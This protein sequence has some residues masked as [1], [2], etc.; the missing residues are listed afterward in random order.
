MRTLR[1]HL[2]EAHD[3]TLQQRPNQ[4]KAM[5]CVAADRASSHFMRTGKYT[6]FTDWRFIHKARLNLLPLNAARPWARNNDQ[7]CRVCGSHPETLPHVL[8][9]CMRQSQA[10]T[11]RHNRI[12]HRIKNAA[13]K[14]FTVTHENRPVGNTNLRPDLVISRGEEAIVL[15]VCCPFENRREALRTAR[16]NKLSKYEPVR[17]FLLQRYQ[18]VAVDA[19]VVGALGSWDP[20]ND[21]TLKRVCSR[22]YLRTM[23]KL[24]VSETISCS[25]NIYVTHVTGQ[26][27]GLPD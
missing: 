14:K 10:L 7:R 21:A 5:E 2:A 18:K 19:V 3:S 15:D 27:Q 11:D 13:L 4:G 26:P 8:C 24:V 16:E 23:K 17:P 20:A 25:R 1:Q 12:V 6:R 22:S 9:H